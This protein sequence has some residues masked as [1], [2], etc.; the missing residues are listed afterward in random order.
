MRR[1]ANESAAGLADKT[2]SEVD[3]LA[4]NDALLPQ[5]TLYSLLG[6]LRSA[7]TQPFNP[8]HV[9]RL[10]RQIEQQSSL[11]RRAEAMHKTVGIFEQASAAARMGVWQCDLPNEHLFWSDGTYDLF[12]LPRNAGLRRNDILKIYSDASLAD[13]E[14]IRGNAIASGS[15]FTLDAE[16]RPSDAAPRWIRISAT[17]ERRN[18]EPV[19]LFGIKQDI[20]EEKLALDRMVYLAGHDVMTGL[21]NRTQFQTQLAA[22]CEPAGSGGTLML[23]DLDGFKDIND[24]LG[25]AIGDACLIETT[26][27]FSVVC[28]SAQLIARIGGDEFAVL[29]GPE[30]GMQAVEGTARRLV[31]AIR[32]PMSCLGQTVVV[33]ASIGFAGAEG[34]SVSSLF[35]RADRALY[36][37]K[38]VGGHT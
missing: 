36:A 30:V 37:A 31:D 2:A 16:I 6:R 9:W 29:F 4:C 34:E 27:K 17:V 15:G 22:I 33:G 24:T 10:R 18:G 13:L 1:S 28:E 21:A 14:R 19:R 12:G 3:A 8:Q 26:R 35:S 7:L 5:S 25:H 32:R 20:T 38:A 11:V 23:I